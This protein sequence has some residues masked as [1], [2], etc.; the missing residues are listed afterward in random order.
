ML[1]W[2]PE[3]GVV[4]EIVSSSRDHQMQTRQQR[5]KPIEEEEYQLVVLGGDYAHPCV[6]QRIQHPIRAIQ[7]VSNAY[8]SPNPHPNPSHSTHLRLL[9]D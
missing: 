8:T 5:V 3:R 2:R 6:H 9:D 4:V 1:M 7:Q